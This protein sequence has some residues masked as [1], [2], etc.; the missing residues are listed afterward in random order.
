M[1][2]I[3]SEGFKINFQNRKWNFPNRKWNYFSTFQASHQKNFFY[4]MFLIRSKGFKNKFQNRKWNYPNRKWNYSSTFQA[5]D[6]KTSFTRCFSFDPRG[7]KLIFKIGNRIIQTGNGIISPPSS[8]LIKKLILQ[9]VLNLGKNWDSMTPPSDLIWEKIETRLESK[10]FSLVKLCLCSKC[11]VLRFFVPRLGWAY[12]LN[13]KL[14]LC[15]EALEKLW[16]FS[17]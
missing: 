7:S 10:V 9:N 15:L 16:V 5:S 6:Q 17:P 8:P 2:L 3:W 13:L 12:V 4:K 1:F 11:L 14:L